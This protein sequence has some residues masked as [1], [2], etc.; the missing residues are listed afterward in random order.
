LKKALF[1]LAAVLALGTTGYLATEGMR[2]PAALL[3][4]AAVMSM[5]AIP[6]QLSTAG[7][8]FT[9]ALI[10][11]SLAAWVALFVSFFT[12]P[13]KEQEDALTG[14]FT[15]PSDGLI[16]KTAKVSGKS[17]IAGLTKAQILERHGAVVV[18]L[19]HN[20]GF[21]INLPITARVRVGSEVLLLGTPA[22]ILATERKKGK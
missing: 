14:L 13:A 4:S 16:M 19:K 12:P 9:V 17:A 7:Q 15:S 1:A 10:I 11:S 6:Q 8:V 22:T 21:D 18:G 20:G 5:A 2:L 3:S